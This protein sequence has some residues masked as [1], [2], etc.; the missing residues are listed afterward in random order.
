MNKK[1]ITTRELHLKRLAMWDK[2]MASHEKF[3]NKETG[4]FDDQ[5]LESRNCPT[6]SG[7][8]HSKLF[9]K[10]GGVYVQCDECQMVFL[11]PVLKNDALEKHYRTNHDL[12]SITVEQDLAFYKELY[13][14]GLNSFQG[15]FSNIP[16]PSILDIGCSAGSFL[17]I[18]KEMNW[19]TYGLEFNHTEAKVSRENKHEV[20]EMDLGSFIKTSNLKFNAITLWDVFEHV[21]NGV[22][23]LEQARSVLELNGGVFIQSPTPTALAARMMQEK[24]NMFDGLEH[25]NLYT[26]DNIKK[27]AAQTGFEIYSYCTV[28]S[29][30]GVINN[31]L[32]YQEPYL[33]ISNTSVLTDLLSD[34]YILD[35]HLGYKF[36]IFLKKK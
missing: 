19:K 35:N 21:K 34:K 25:V 30:S 4:F 11:N 36:Q 2:G 28:V 16:N 1:N 17:N 33:G 31:Y 29:E 13:I 27:L 26:Y 32:D 7:E 23:L 5:F 18:A 9:L 10:S 6:C 24:C 22:E 20:F 3:L 8:K 14:K 12:Q 15:L